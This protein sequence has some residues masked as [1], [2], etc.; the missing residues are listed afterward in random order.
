MAANA[1]SDLE[2]REYH[3]RIKRDG[4]EGSGNIGV[5]QGGS[6]TNII[7]EYLYLKGEVRSHDP[8]FRAHLHEVYKQAF[9][10]AAGETRHLQSTD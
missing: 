10:K 6:G 7:M 2:A 4:G 9:Q 1:I 5:I 8:K 3:G